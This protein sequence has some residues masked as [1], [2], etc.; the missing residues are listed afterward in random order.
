MTKQRYD[1]VWIWFKITSLA[2]SRSKTSQERTKFNIKSGDK[3]KFDIKS[4][5]Q[6]RHTGMD[7]YI[8]LWS[9]AQTMFGL[10]WYREAN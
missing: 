6:T 2:E 1:G 7:V 9:C 3:T 5:E 4:K 10:I 8:L